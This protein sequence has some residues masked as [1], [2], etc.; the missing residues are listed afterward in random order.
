ME[1]NFSPENSKEAWYRILVS[2]LFSWIF[3]GIG[4]F[5][6]VNNIFLLSNLFFIFVGVLIYILVDSILYISIRNEVGVKE[7]YLLV[8]GS[9]IAFIVNMIV[10]YGYINYL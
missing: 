3:F 2:L 4:L 7:N 6:D 1:F 9:V 8:I 10:F 5:L